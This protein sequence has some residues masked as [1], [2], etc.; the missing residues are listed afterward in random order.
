MQYHKELRNKS[1]TLLFKKKI[2]LTKPIE[3]GNKSINHSLDNEVNN[4]LKN[5]IPNTLKAIEKD[6]IVVLIS[7][8]DSGYKQDMHNSINYKVY[9]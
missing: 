5:Y 2:D 9:F 4:I 6:K 3:F 1:A 7:Y 8:R